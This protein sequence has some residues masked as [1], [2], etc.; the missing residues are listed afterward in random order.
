MSLAPYSVM[1]VLASDGDAEGRKRFQ[2]LLKAY[3]DEP[4]TGIGLVLGED[5]DATL[6]ATTLSG[7][8]QQFSAARTLWMKD[9][10]PLT[11][12]QAAAWKPDAATL[13]TFLTVERKVS[14]HLSMPEAG[15]A[16]GLTLALLAALAGET[17]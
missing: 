2:A 12:A 11:A 4:T 17:T 7:M 3:L 6:A 5:P 15:E 13:V 16:S 9:L 10:R 8:A 14:S 1:P